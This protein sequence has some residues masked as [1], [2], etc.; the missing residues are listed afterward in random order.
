MSFSQDLADK[1][2][3]YAVSLGADYCDARAEKQTRNSVLIEN[4]E[5]EHVRKKSDNGIGLRI[6]KNGA[7]GF[8]SITN[9]KSFDKIKESI[10]KTLKN[11]Q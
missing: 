2:I 8:C 10:E 3:S 1:A 5:I 9:P 4:G 6:L 7:W 11:T